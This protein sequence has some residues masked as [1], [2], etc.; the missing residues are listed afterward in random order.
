MTCSKNTRKTCRWSCGSRI[1][2]LSRK[3][4]STGNLLAWR[5][6]S[7]S[8]DLELPHAWHALRIEVKVISGFS[9]WPRRNE[10]RYFLKKK[11][12]YL[13]NYG[14]QE[15]LLTRW[16]SLIFVST[17]PWPHVTSIYYNLVGWHRPVHSTVRE[18]HNRDACSKKPA[19]KTHIAKAV[20]NSESTSDP[21][22]KRVRQNRVNAATIDVAHLADANGREDRRED[23]RNCQDERGQ[24]QTRINDI[25]L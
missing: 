7:V 2:P 13:S 19:R 20:E 1:R 3:Q 4:F 10:F 21:R 18:R 25:Q 12:E 15:L 11:T 8:W 22:A 14:H 24:N 9:R 23:D 6:F 16:T 5:N 17:A